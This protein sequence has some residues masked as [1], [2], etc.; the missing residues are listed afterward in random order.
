M[1]CADDAS[2]PAPRPWTVEAPEFFPPGPLLLAAGG[3][4]TCAQLEDSLVRCWGFDGDRSNDSV[5]PEARRQRPVII[6]GLKGVLE[7]KVGGVHACA[8]LRD[9]TV[10]CWGSNR[11]GQL[12]DGTTQDRLTPVT[13]RGLLNVRGLALGYSHSCA[14]IK[15][16]T[17]RCWGHNQLGSLGDGSFLDKLKPVEVKGLKSIRQLSAGY[18]HTCASFAYSDARCWGA[19]S[20]A[21]FNAN[22]PAIPIARRIEGLGRSTYISSG[23]GSSMI[24]C[25]VGYN[26]SSIKCWGYNAQGQLGDGTTESRMNPGFVSDFISESFLFTVG[27][28]HVCATN[29]SRAALCWGSNQYGQLGAGVEGDRATTPRLVPEATEVSQISAGFNHTCMIKYDDTVWCWGHNH[30]GQLG[31]GTTTDRV[32]P[33]QVLF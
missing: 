12:G 23:G 6:E 19:I 14:L 8:R 32:K 11:Y 9:S 15:D 22:T 3:F 28:H 17:A 10:R 29:P 4:Q 30:L 25:M 27:G 21:Q 26:Y 7:L 2:S 31:D 18:A 1:S 24:S 13:V 16:G 33:V 20:E 5:P